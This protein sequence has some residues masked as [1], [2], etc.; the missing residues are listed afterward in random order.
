MCLGLS[1]C[2]RMFGLRLGDAGF[3]MHWLCE[4]FGLHRGICV[5]FAALFLKEPCGT[6]WQP[7]CRSCAA[8]RALQQDI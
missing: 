7:V 2:L 6:Q 3:K 4:T 5:R 1:Y 8:V